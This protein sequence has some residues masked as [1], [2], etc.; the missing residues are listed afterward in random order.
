MPHT[1]PER[2]ETEDEYVHVRYRDPDEFDTIRTPDWADEASDSVSE[3]S[4]VRM[5]READGDDWEV[6]SVLIAKSVGE[7]TARKQADEIVEKIQ[8]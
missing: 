7:E 8:S 2:V 6:Q 3:G 4:E 5:G 1:D